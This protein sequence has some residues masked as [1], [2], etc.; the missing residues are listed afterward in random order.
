MTEKR[1]TLVT[2]V[3]SHYNEKARWSL[4]H[5]GI[6]HHEKAYLPGFSQ[7]GV[8]MATGGK[9]G[10]ADAVSSRFS[11]PILL[12][13]SGEKLCDSTD[14]AEWA[15]KQIGGGGP[16]PLFPSPE[17]R[18]LVVDLGRNLGP[19]TRLV[20]YARVFRSKTAM[21]NM[22]KR[23]VGAAQA[24]AFRAMSPLGKRYLTKFLGITPEREA[25]A[26]ERVWEQIERMDARL[27]RSPYLAGDRFTAADITFA[28]LLSPA[29]LVQPEE[30]HG[31]VLPRLDE[32]DE[33][34]R[35]LIAKVRGTQA[36]AF[37][38]EMYRDH[39]RNGPKTHETAEKQPRK[40]LI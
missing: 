6:A 23:N 2:L 37:A 14:I 40:N 35:V 22:A 21:A 30:G 16:G 5:C 19:Y 1:P 26:L 33:E 7:L 27:E 13:P 36:G 34:T 39:R 15:S 32:M 4:D 31:A 9:G 11:T 24:F 3:F 17:V 10:A 38:L 20:A 25:R 12:L 18:E 28:S 29:L 8:M